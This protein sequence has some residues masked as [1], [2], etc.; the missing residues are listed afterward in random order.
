VAWLSGWVRRK[1]HTINGSTAGAQINYQV[2]IVA[3]KATGTD[4]GEDVYLG[5]N[6]RDDFG[7]V[8]FTKADGVTLLDYWMQEYIS[9]DKAIFWV[10]VDSIP[11]SPDSVVIY[12]YYDKPDA[13][14]ISNGDNTFILFDDFP[15]T[16]V[17]TSKWSIVQGDFVVANSELKMTGGEAI[18]GLMD[19][20]TSISINSAIHTRA[21]W[22]TTRAEWHHFC[23]L[24]R[25]LDWNY[26]VEMYGDGVGNIR[27]EVRDAGTA[28]YATFTPS[29]PTSYHIYKSTWISGEA[30]FY[31]DDTLKITLT[32]N[33]PTID[34]VAVF[35]EGINSGEDVYVDWI[36]IRKYVDPEPS[37][38][39]WGSEEIVV[40]VVE[41][42][43]ICRTSVAPIIVA[44]PIIR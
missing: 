34:L 5:T 32:T 42:P 43:L 16:A 14:S 6:V 26:R 13:V 40:V 44:K 24:R 38:G 31:Q 4:S 37:H 18:R 27:C 1:S 35:Y 25:T 8:R 3:H 2:K 29:T 15:G 20:I 23:S 33:V 28:S 10:E 22:S 12:I 21:K 39:A 30:K 9:G 7:D 11:A 17:D 19:S 41:H 36:F